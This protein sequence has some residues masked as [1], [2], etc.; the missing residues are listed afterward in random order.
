MPWCVL[1]ITPSDTSILLVKDIIQFTSNK[2]CLWAK[3]NLLPSVF[4]NYYKLNAEMHN[5]QTR[6]AGQLHNIKKTK[7]VMGDKTIKVSGAKIYKTLPDYLIGSSSASRFKRQ[8]CS[9]YIH[10]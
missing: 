8:L 4:R 3:N 5:L 7:T 9:F 10:V 6:Q 1:H 2:M